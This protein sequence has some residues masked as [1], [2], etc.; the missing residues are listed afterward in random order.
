MLH[1]VIVGDFKLEALLFAKPII[2]AVCGS[3]LELYSNITAMI[4]RAIIH[5]MWWEGS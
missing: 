4:K 1:T 2:S 3:R 5:V